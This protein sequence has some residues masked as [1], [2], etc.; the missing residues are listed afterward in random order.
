M[1]HRLGGCTCRCNQR[2][3]HKFG[4]DVRSQRVAGVDERW[5]TFRK[6]RTAAAY[7]DRA[8]TYVR[9]ERVTLHSNGAA[10][11]SSI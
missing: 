6:F 3:I 2:L 4:F 5:R 8:G 9:E 10:I 1:N 7:E 11:P